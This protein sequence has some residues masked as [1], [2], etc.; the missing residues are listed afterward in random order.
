MWQEYTKLVNSKSKNF[1]KTHVFRTKIHGWHRMLSCNVFQNGKIDSKSILSQVHMRLFLSNV[2]LR[3]CCYH[4]NYA[5]LQRFTDISIGDFWGIEKTMPEF[6]DNKGVSLVLTN[7]TKGE[8]LLA[9]VTQELELRKSNPASC[10]QGNLEHPTP[11]PTQR[12]EFWSY[13]H[14]HGYEQA[15]KKYAGY[16]RLHQ[17]KQ[18]IYHWLRSFKF[19]HY[20]KRLLH[21][22]RRA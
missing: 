2:L 4:C 11:Y 13:Y 1:L 19:L 22:V 3:P 16:S 14:V 7:T 15:S 17:L 18:T 21:T 9:A 8:E 10:L 12:E 5:T 20:L 6:D